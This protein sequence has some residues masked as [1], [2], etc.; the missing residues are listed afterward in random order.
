M[1]TFE[2]DFLLL[3]IKETFSRGDFFYREI[4]IFFFFEIFLKTG[5]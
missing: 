2:K 4:F 1:E 3:Q 5:F